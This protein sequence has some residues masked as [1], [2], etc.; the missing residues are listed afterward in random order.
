[1]TTTV[2]FDMDGVIVDSEYTFLESKTAMLHSEGHLVDE[3]YHY[4][5]MGTTAEFMWEKMKEELQ[6]QK[7]V[8][9]YIEEMNRRRKAL[10]TRDGVKAIPHV[11]TLIRQLAE[12]NFQL[13]VASSSHKKEI[14][15]NLDQLQ[16]RNYFTEIVSSEEVARSKPFPDVF[17]KAASLL[18]A[19]PQQCIVIE[20]TINGCK[21]AKAAGMYCIGFANPAF[22]VQGLP[23]DQ[24]IIDF[25]DLN[26]QELKTIK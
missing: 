6:L 14:E 9:A 10:I 22:P 26:V 24:T 7:S 8:S 15:E 12:A 1:M 16:L 25:R 3:S 4:Q 11:Q 18:S 21:A 17:L 19:N 13:G 2:I 5:F 23:A 20:D